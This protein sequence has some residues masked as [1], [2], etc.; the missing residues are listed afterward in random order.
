MTTFE[1][2][3]KQRPIDPKRLKE[4][5]QK[6]HEEARAYEEAQDTLYAEQAPEFNQE[7]QARR[8]SRR[9]RLSEE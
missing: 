3:L 4:K 1:E 8:A 9:K 5:V 7:A 6:M 2:M